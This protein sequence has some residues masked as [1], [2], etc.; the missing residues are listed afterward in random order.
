MDNDLR[1]DELYADMY[2]SLRR[3]KLMQALLH[4]LPYLRSKDPAKM[5][6]LQNR[7]S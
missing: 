7:L 1:T 6:L 5:L 4:E 2:K 3:M